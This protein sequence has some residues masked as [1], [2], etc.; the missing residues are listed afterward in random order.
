M[1]EATTR[2]FEALWHIIHYQAPG[3][4]L[5]WTRGCI[6]KDTGITSDST[7][8]DF[9]LEIKLVFQLPRIAGHWKCL[10]LTI[11]ASETPDLSFSNLYFVRFVNVAECFNNLSR[12]SFQS[13]DVKARLCLIIHPFTARS[14]GYVIIDVFVRYWLC[15]SKL[16][17]IWKDLIVKR[18]LCHRASNSVWR[19]PCLIGTAAQVESDRV[20]SCSCATWQLQL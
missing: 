12:E 19:Q 2:L 13:H 5:S 9:R 1:V 20:R 8:L 11:D 6:L 10:N 15:S 16:V 3:H 4:K 17:F 7:Y 18:L 14:T